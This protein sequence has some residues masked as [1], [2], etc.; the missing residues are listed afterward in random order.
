M[1]TESSW[2][3]LFGATV[4]L[5]LALGASALSAP[6]VVGP[7]APKMTETPIPVVDLKAGVN[8]GGLAGADVDA[9]VGGSSGATVGAEAVGSGAQVDGG[10]RAGAGSNAAG[11]TAKVDADVDTGGI[12]GPD[13]KTSGGAKAGAGVNA[14]AG[15]GAAGADVDAD[16]NADTNAGAGGA[17]V[18]AGV[19]AGTRAGAAGVDVDAG[20]NAGTNAGAGG[21]GV[22]VAADGGTTGLNTDV[23]AGVSPGPAMRDTNVSASGT[24]GTVPMGAHAPALIQTTSSI[25]LPLLP[26]LGARKGDRADDAGATGIRDTQLAMLGCVDPLSNGHCPTEFET[27][28]GAIP[29]PSIHFEIVNVADGAANATTSAVVQP[30][31]G[32]GP[33]YP[34][35]RVSQ[36]FGVF[37]TDPIRTRTGLVVRCV[38]VNTSGRTQPIPPLDVRLLNS[39]GDVVGHS[40][41][42]APSN[43]LAGGEDQTFKLRIRLLPPDATRLTVSLVSPT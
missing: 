32:A 2:I 15:A 33:T 28:A 9:S 37:L 17:N 21:A 20:V 11:G 43:A 5:V 8:S 26:P 31:Q 36:R 25:L 19:N 22:G 42:S 23:S 7:D 29:Q 6:T 13:S 34:E 12:A 14:D 27:K 10:V 1:P 35:P 40:V 24:P 41:L 3:T 38:I 18:G 39:A 30:A 4:A 16:V